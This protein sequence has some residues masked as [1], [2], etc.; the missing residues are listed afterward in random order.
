MQNPADIDDVC[1]LVS[2]TGHFDVVSSI[3]DC[4]FIEIGNTYPIVRKYK[5]YWPVRDMLKLHLKYTSESSRKK[6]GKSHILS[7]IIIKN[8]PG[9]S[10]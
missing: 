2:L 6:K 10:K 4:L 8:H 5:N 9:G 1:I 3:S 7:L